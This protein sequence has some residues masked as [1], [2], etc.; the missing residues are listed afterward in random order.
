MDRTGKLVDLILKLAFESAA[1]EIKTLV[2][3]RWPDD[4]TL[5]C[6]WLAKKF[7]P[8]ATDAKIVF[9][10]AG[11]T[12]PGSDNDASVLHFDTGGGDFDQHNKNLKK[13][14]SA[15]I[16]VEKMGWDDP[17]LQPLLDMVTA[18]D[19]IEPQPKTSIHFIIEGYPRK[20]RNPDKTI[21]W[22]LVIDRTFELFDII[23][24]QEVQRIQS[25]K[26]LRTHAGISLL[27]NGIKLTSILGYP[28]LREAAFEDGADVVVWT[29]NRGEKRFHTGIQVNRNSDLVLT[30][31]AALLREREARSRGINAQGK[32]LMYAGKD[33][34][35][36]GV[37]YLH[38]SSLRLILNG[39]RSYLPVKEEYTRLSP[40]DIIQITIQALGKIP[41]E[42]V[43]RWK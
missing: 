19:N 4:D 30:K 13:T 37:W 39:S 10:N 34:V 29:E 25:Q 15:S 21:D 3:H 28:S 35:D 11:K 32:N 27:P 2:G 6:L 16:L 12:L 24:D 38:D 14:S 23:Y 22:P 20:F 7:I 9:V 33:D 43:S 31:V 26:S 5:F 17:G 1:P 36:A 8:N 41:R 40:G 42:V 18:T